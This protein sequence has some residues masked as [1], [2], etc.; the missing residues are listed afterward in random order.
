MF[1]QG[2][3]S[4]IPFKLLIPTN[5]A[6]FPSKTHLLFEI[7]IYVLFSTA[8]MEFGIILQM[9]LDNRQKSMKFSCC[10]EHLFLS[11]IY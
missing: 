4:I 3:F 6:S 11:I 9:Y 10:D 7:H 5:L 1:Q 2:E 8:S